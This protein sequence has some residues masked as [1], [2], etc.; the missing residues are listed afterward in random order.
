MLMKNPRGHAERPAQ[1]Q[2]RPVERGS[3][4]RGL[5]T[6]A[7][8]AVRIGAVPRRT[9]EL[10]GHVGGE[11]RERPGV[12]ASRVPASL[13]PRSSRG[14]VYSSKSGKSSPA[15]VTCRKAIRLK[16]WDPFGL[17]C[18]THQAP[19]RST[20]EIHGLLTRRGD[21]EHQADAKAH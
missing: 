6:L 16:L 20:Q 18:R 1:R 9:P 11:A 17:P 7:C 10:S 13:H 15:P 19:C 3:G 21:W 8:D 5:L 4:E 14:S 2:G 12:P